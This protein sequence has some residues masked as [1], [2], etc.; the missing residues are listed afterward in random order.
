MCPIR[1]GAH[2]GPMFNSYEMTKAFVN[3]RQETLRHE[4]RQHR[5]ATAF[6]RGRGATTSTATV[7]LA[8]SADPTS[9]VTRSDPDQQAA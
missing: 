7:R 6:R 4:A 9:P 5:L 2:D 1:V 3:E 8:T